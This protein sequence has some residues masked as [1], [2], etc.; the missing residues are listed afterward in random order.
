MI[1]SSA[2]KYTVPIAQFMTHYIRYNILFI[3]LFISS[4]ISPQFSLRSTKQSIGHIIRTLHS[5]GFSA[6]DDSVYHQD[7]SMYHSGIVH[8]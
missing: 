5:F 3:Y 2:F 8:N 7:V 4:R 1:E 6:S